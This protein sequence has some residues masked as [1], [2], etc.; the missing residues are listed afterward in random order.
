VFFVS[1]TSL[2][3]TVHICR[4][5][6]E[7]KVCNCAKMGHCMMNCNIHTHS[8]SHKA[9][10]K[11]NCCTTKTID[12]SVKAEYLSQQ[13]DISG[14]SHQLIAVITLNPFDSIEKIIPLKEYF[15]GISPPLI[16][17]NNLFLTNSVLLI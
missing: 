4:M 1:T 16:I 13:S 5:A 11:N 12:T 14:N 3:V 17:G 6:K 15:P 2:P 9:S 7:S 10:V 8:F